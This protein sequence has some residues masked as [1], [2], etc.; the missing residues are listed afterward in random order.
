MEKLRRLL[1]EA[2]TGYRSIGQAIAGQ[3]R[4]GHDRV[5]QV[6]LVP[7]WGTS[8]TRNIAGTLDANRDAF[9]GSAVA[10]GIPVLSP[11]ERLVRESQAL[12]SVAARYHDVGRLAG[13][14]AEKVLTG[15]ARPGDLPVA[16][17]ADFAFVIN[18]AV[19]RELDLFPPLELLQIAETV[20]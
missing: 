15:G 2:E 4:P 16:P 8:V 5:E 9:T 18:M 11:Y 1:D 10:N 6:D 20:N 19:A 13:V 7:N 17:I 12:I 3:G 14:Q